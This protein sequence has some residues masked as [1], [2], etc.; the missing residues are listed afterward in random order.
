MKDRKRWGLRREINAGLT[1]LWQ[2]KPLNTVLNPT[3]GDYIFCF[4]RTRGHQEQLECKKNSRTPRLYS[5][6]VPLLAIG[7]SSLD[8]RHF[9][10]RWFGPLALIRPPLRPSRKIPDPPLNI[11]LPHGRPCLT[12]QILHF[13]LSFSDPSTTLQHCNKCCNVLYFNSI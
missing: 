10:P 4:L 9:G 1:R 11:G 5:A 8:L 6:P 3:I 13:L 2:R 7:L 12:F